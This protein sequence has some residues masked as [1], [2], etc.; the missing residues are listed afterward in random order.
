[1]LYTRA[2]AA[3]GAA[4]YAPVTDLLRTPPVRRAL[5]MLDPVWR[6][7]V[8]RLLPDLLPE[9]SAPPPPLVEAWQQQ[10][11]HAALARACVAVGEPLLL[12]VDD[13]QWCDAET[14]AWL[15]M[16]LRCEPPANLL[17]VATVRG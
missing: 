8:A 4:A 6:V 14:L 7:E 17:V 1:T 13:V 5:E 15:H 16:L 9:S 12:H 3:Q 11:F 2:Y 10:R